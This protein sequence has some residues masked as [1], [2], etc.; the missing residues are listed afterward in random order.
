MG[1]Y[2]GLHVDGSPE[3]IAILLR[4]ELNSWKGVYQSF[5]MSS[6]IGFYLISNDTFIGG[7]CVKI[8]PCAK[9]SREDVYSGDQPKYV[10][11]DDE[12]LGLY[13]ACAKGFRSR[14]QGRYGADLDDEAVLNVELRWF[15]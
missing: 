4:V 3:I 14:F 2:H 7:V 10:L 5:Q 12:T 13:S 1:A 8:C 6:H 15:Y 11:H 9:K